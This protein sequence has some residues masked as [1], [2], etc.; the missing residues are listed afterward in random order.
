MSVGLQ[1]AFEFNL[2][3]P[4]NTRD[5]TVERE[6]QSVQNT[7]F[8]RHLMN[9]KRMVSSSYSF[10]EREPVIC[11]GEMPSLSLVYIQNAFRG[12]WCPPD[13]CHFVA[14]S[15]LFFF[16]QKLFDF[17]QQSVP[18]FTSVTPKYPGKGDLCLLLIPWKELSDLNSLEALI[19]SF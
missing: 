6:I 1:V 14:F 3:S 15:F 4:L 7:C 16:F 13:L 18:Q 19:T 5:F 17:Y 11:L 10:S 9:H 8:A 2:S 12:L